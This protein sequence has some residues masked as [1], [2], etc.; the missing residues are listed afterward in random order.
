[1]RVHIIQGNTFKLDGGAMFG[2]VPKPLW[3]KWIPSDDQNRITLACRS[4]LIQ[5]DS[6]RNV[7]LEAGIG[8]FFE[9]KMKERYGIV[10]NENKLLVYLAELGVKESDIDTIILTHLHFDH[11]GGLLSPFHEGPLRLLFPK[12]KYYI[13][14]EHWIRALKP[15]SRERHSFIPILND[16]IARS[17]RLVLLHGSHHPDLNFG[18]RFHRSDGHTIGLLLPEIALPSGPLLYASD[19]IPGIPWMHLPVTMGYDRFSEL[20]VEEKRKIL[21]DLFERKGNL[22]FT[23]DPTIS[24]AKINKDENGKFEAINI[25][26]VN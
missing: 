19:L 3:Q 11:A 22:L 12:A 25:T 18:V 8:S 1:M 2:N 7:L 9:P 26:I 10:E 15:P 16:F 23:H 20:I 13:S 17:D 24:C 14:S 5:L 6:G 21:D 4:L